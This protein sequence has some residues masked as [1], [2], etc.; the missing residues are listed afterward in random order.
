MD[1]A[2]PPVPVLLGP[3]PSVSGSLPWSPRLSP[4]AGGARWGHLA[5]PPWEPQLTGSCEMRVQEGERAGVGSRSHRD[6]C[7]L[8]KAH[9][10]PAVRWCEAGGPQRRMNWIPRQAGIM[11]QGQS[12]ILLPNRCCPGLAVL[13]CLTSLP[14]CPR[15]QL[16][17]APHTVPALSDAGVSPAPAPWP[18]QLTGM[19]GGC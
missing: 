2:Q 11:T 15:R 12:I 4:R 6:L 1:E 3:R 5:G 17:P 14:T 9:L 7:F 16:P 8:S 10:K 19:P 13:S 18:R